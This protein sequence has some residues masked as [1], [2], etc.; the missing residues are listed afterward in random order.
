MRRRK[1]PSSGQIFGPSGGGR[2]KAMRTSLIPLLSDWE[3]QE[4]AACR[5]MDSS[6]FFSPAGE[7]G[8]RRTRRE[9]RARRICGRCEV[10]EECGAMALDYKE[11]Y[12]VWGGMSAGERRDVL[13]SAPGPAPM[14]SSPGPARPGPAPSAA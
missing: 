7:R 5:G 1:A 2:R 4:K 3:W 8:R 9:E 13:G 11:H 12:G 10:V 6:M 14:T